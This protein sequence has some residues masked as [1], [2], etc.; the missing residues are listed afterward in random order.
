MIV[1]PLINPVIALIMGILILI[2]P[3]FLNYF[4]AFYLIIVGILGL[5]A[6]G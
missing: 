4:V 6:L 5:A 1:H 3:A 2:F